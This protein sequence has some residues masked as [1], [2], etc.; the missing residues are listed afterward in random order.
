ML[1][2]AGLGGHRIDNDLADWMPE[3]M[4]EGGGGEWV[5]IGLPAER[6]GVRTLLALAAALRARPEFVRVVDPVSLAAA[7]ALGGPDPAGLT[8]RPGDPMTATWAFGR[9]DVPAA[10]LL[11]AVHAVLTDAGFD[12][13]PVASTPMATEDPSVHLAGPAVFR[14]ALNQWSQRG[15]AGICGLQIL[16]CLILF[17]VCDGRW[18]AAVAGAGAIAGVQ[19]ILLGTFAWHRTPLDLALSLVP[20]LVA[21]LGASFVMH[22]SMRRG[23][24]RA[25]VASC[26]TSMLGIGVFAF[27]GLLPLLRFGTWGATGVG[28]AALA[29][30]TLVPAAATPIAANE[31]G[32]RPRLR[33]VA[34]SLRGLE[35]LGPRRFPA[36]L[37]TCLLLIAGGL[38]AVPAL[39]FQEDPLRG[40]PT[41]AA[42]RRDFE[43]IDATV[44]GMLPL[45]VTVSRGDAGG[46]DGFDPVPLIEGDGGVRRLISAPHEPGRWWGLAS[47]DSAARL[48]AAMPGWRAAAAAAGA[49]LEC[50]GVGP[51]LAA[52]GGT[53]REIAAGS[54]PLMVAVAAVAGGVI[55][56][57]VRAAVAAGLVNAVPSAVLV[58]MAAIGGIELGLPALLVAAIATGAGIDD[59]VH[60]IA[61]ARTVGPRRARRRCAMAC[62]GS[63]LVAAVSAGMFLGSPFGPVAQF[64]G[65][66]AATLVAAVAAD[67]LL[68]PPLL[69]SGRRIAHRS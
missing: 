1:A 28:L 59:S 22:R 34:R 54:I 5:V 10:E 68:L 20:P 8:G 2:A 66:M 62:L 64:G 42:V 63:T 44:A 7:S 13:A 39:R 33:R 21:A 67:L 4:P 49:T 45:E 36:A 19:L 55:G 30:W 9:E 47:N 57:S 51:A 52:I 46:G 61:A 43:A 3:A 15:L 23:S 50:R 53:V 56:R 29:A 41:D 11:D 16:A 35:R 65:L 40:F 69:G 24:G 58:M 6:A 48:R 32:R 25:I 38:L 14:V 60:L 17:R 37:G 26:L 18:S 31:P 12:V 27:G